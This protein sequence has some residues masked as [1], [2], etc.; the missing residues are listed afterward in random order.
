MPSESEQTEWEA[1]WK[2]AR[3]ENERLLEGERRFRRAQWY[4]AP[5]VAIVG[6]YFFPEKAAQFIYWGIVGFCIYVAVLVI[7]VPIAGVLNL[8]ETLRNREPLFDDLKAYKKGLRTFFIIM[9][10]LGPIIAL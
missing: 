3:A 6:V 10:I 1:K 9:M 7:A 2:A 5:V 4:A 8:I